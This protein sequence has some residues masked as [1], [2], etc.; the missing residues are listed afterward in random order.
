MLEVKHQVA[1]VICMKTRGQL[2]G[3][4]LPGKKIVLAKA[5]VQVVVDAPNDIEAE[6]YKALQNAA[7]LDLYLNRHPGQKVSSKRFPSIRDQWEKGIDI[8]KFSSQLALSL[9]FDFKRA[10]I[11]PRMIAVAGQN[12]AHIA[13]ESRPWTTIEAFDA[14]RACADGWR[15]EHCLKTLDD[16]QSLSE[17]LRFNIVRTQ[18]RLASKPTLNLAKDRPLHDVLRRGFLRAYAHQ[19]LGLTPSFKSYAALA[20]WLTENGYPTKPSEPRSAKSQELVLGFAPKTDD[21]MVLWHLLKAR[22]PE[23]RLEALLAADDGLSGS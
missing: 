6:P 2:T 7:M 9:E 13:L 14:A 18:L 19:A 1:Q 21:M 16:W 3:Q 5:G 10:P 12:Q 4:A 20:S 22:F 17:L 23:A 11:N 8:I 15:R